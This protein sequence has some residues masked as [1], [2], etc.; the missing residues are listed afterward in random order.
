[1][2]NKTSFLNQDLLLASEFDEIILISD[3]D[4]VIREGVSQV[5]DGR[6]I[7]IFQ[8]LLQN[9]KVK[10]IFISGTPITNQQTEVWCKGNLPLKD[11]FGSSFQEE[12][13]NGRVTIFGVLGAHQMAGDGSLQIMDEYPLEVLFE[14]GGLLIKAFLKEVQIQGDA[15][16]KKL[17]LELEKHLQEV[18]LQD[19]FQ[20]TCKTP[21]EFSQIITQIQES[22]DPAFRLISN[23][24][25]IETQTSN[26][27]WSTQLSYAWLQ[28]Q[29]HNSNY[30]ISRFDEEQKKIA[31]GY[32]KKGDKGF[33]YLMISK[34]DKGQTIKK[35]LEQK[36][37]SKRCVVTIGDTQV[38]FPMHKHADLS[39]HVGLE[40]VWKQYAMPHCYIIRNQNGEDSQHVEGTLLILNYLEKQLNRG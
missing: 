4:G 28:E 20:S 15:F 21:N 36:K 12:L 10:L 7:E 14:L 30:L 29:M 13:Q 34:V 9:Q 38:D 6:V 8:K 16:Q 19:A 11:A 25:L 23:G 40:S 32:A 31:T 27:P 33:N 17:A 22:I 37:I 5:A 35:H 18:R 3:V 39:F 1:M 2:I 26:P 24:A